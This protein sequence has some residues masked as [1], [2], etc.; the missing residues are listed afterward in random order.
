MVPAERSH[1]ANESM[2]AVRQL[3]PGKIYRETAPYRGQ[4]V[5]QIKA[6]MSFSYPQLLYKRVLKKFVLES[7]SVSG[8]MTA[9]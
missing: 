3:F 1:I 2:N 6:R 7:K 5:H 8:L 9:I 4:L